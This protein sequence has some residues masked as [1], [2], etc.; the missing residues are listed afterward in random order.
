MAKKIKKVLAL[1]LA[2]AI[3]AGQIVL[4]SAAAEITE[5]PIEGGT[6][7]ITV[8]EEST[9]SGTGITTSE[10][11][12]LK[13]WEQEIIDDETGS[14]TS[15]EG[16]ETTVKTEVSD[17][18]EYPMYEGETVKGSETAT[19]TGETHTEDR[20]EG[21]PVTETTDNDFVYDPQ[22][23]TDTGWITDPGEAGEDTY[24]DAVLSQKPGDVTLDLTQKDSTDT[25]TI[26]LDLS[27]AVEENI[28]LP[29]PGTTELVNDDGSITRTLVEYIYEGSVVIGYTKTVTTIHTETHEDQDYTR[30]ET[31]TG[32]DSVTNA[33]QQKEETL[34]L[35]PAEP[36]GGTEIAED[37]SISVSTVE[38]ILNEN[39]DHIGFKTITVTTHPDGTVT[40]ASE[41]IYGTEVK[42]STETT[43]TDTT[44]TETTQLTKDKV[45]TTTQVRFQDAEGFELVWD[46]VNWVYAAELGDVKAGKDHGNVEITPLTPTSLVLNGKTYVVNRSD[47][48]VTPVGSHTSPEG[49]DYNYT[50]VRGEGSNYAVGTSNSYDSDA[51]MFQL[52]VGNDTFYVYCVDFAV[53]ATPNYNYTMENVADAT[54]YGEEESKHIQAIGMYGYWG[55][56]GT[57]ENGNPVKGSLAALKANL[58]AARNE[59]VEAGKSFPLTQ[60]QIN[61]MTEGEALTATQAAFWTYGN[62]G[63]T[64][65]DETQ[66]T[67]KITGLYEWLIGLEA[68]TT[69]STDIIEE[70]EFAQSASV[71]VKDKVGTDEG[72]DIYKTDV[73]F[74]IDVTQSSLTG[75]LKVSVIQDGKVVG[76]VQLATAGSNILGK[77]MAGGKEVG[78]SVT[79]TDLELVEGVKFTIQLDGTQELEE[80]V[81]IYTSEKINGKPSQTFVG[82]AK[83]EHTVDLAVDMKFTVTEPDVLVKDPGAKPGQTRIETETQRKTDIETV[84]TKTQDIVSDISTLEQTKREWESSWE[85]EY[86]YQYDPEPY[87]GDGDDDDEEIIEEE[88]VPLADAPQTGD[89]SLLFAAVSTL[90][91][92]GLLVLNRKREDE[93]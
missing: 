78:T 92:G 30:G 49:Y 18:P 66:K 58:T 2:L 52:K 9:E 63:T 20:I 42:S 7:T 56:T 73:S 85:K 17:G 75:N 16:T 21:D 79:F 23:D 19:K 31:V 10:E 59:A 22:L 51:H 33:P 84:T 81:Y 50:G 74:T 6:L 13:Q 27:K 48:S 91:L 72:R 8:T 87:N 41:S 15:I 36:S 88:E 25:E 76:E 4:P 24:T 45:T 32:T 37:G 93:V 64:T 44:V 62:S 86:T 28:D 57:D 47:S 53:T 67:A 14:I 1:M 82:L 5:T 40:N 55:T 65:I 34:F 69:Q 29:A 43:T 60:K 46:G 11:T 80:G 54:Y 71:T 3:C 38:K 68:P 35:L 77:L 89:I 70:E 61:A 90:S 83:G 39:G 12:T 26:L